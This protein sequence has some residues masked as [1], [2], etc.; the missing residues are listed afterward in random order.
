MYLGRAGQT[1]RID[2]NKPVVPVTKFQVQ[3]L[4]PDVAVDQYGNKGF[5]TLI[6]NQGFELVIGGRKYFA[7]SQFKKEGKVVT[8][9]CDKTFNGWVHDIVKPIAGQS[10]FPPTNW[11]CYY[12]KYYKVLVG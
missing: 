12:G 3:L 8:S 7:F 6:Y 9:I 10:E 11:G 1:N 2:C 4:F 5:W